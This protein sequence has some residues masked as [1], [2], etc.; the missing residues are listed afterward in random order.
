MQCEHCSCFL[1]QI[2]A[3]VHQDIS[4]IL[5]CGLPHVRSCRFSYSFHLPFELLVVK[6][7]GGVLLLQRAVAVLLWLN[8]NRVEIV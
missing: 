1:E 3:K 5:F 7:R 4:I 8:L 6:L 2:E